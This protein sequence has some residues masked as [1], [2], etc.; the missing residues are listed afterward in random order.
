VCQTAKRNEEIWC[1]IVGI[2][3]KQTDESTFNLYMFT[4]YIIFWAIKKNY[5]T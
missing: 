4:A 2:K 5:I 3:N 1:K